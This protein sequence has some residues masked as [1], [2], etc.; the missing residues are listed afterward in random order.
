MIFLLGNMLH[1]HHLHTYITWSTDDG[2]GLPT[3]ML[4]KVWWL[5]VVLAVLL[6]DNTCDDTRQW[7]HPRSEFHQRSLVVLTIAHMNSVKVQWRVKY[8]LPV[9]RFIL[10][11]VYLKKILNNG[12]LHFEALLYMT[13]DGKRP[14]L[15]MVTWKFKSL[16]TKKTYINHNIFID[17]DIISLFEKYL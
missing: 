14:K 4:V 16:L 11:Y 9:S 5:L 10:L 15:L 12:L 1:I 13:L 7:S 6:V 17:H 2:A 3:V 8:F